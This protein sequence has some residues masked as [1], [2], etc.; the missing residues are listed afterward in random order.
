M[1]AAMGSA[2]DRPMG[3]MGQTPPETPPRERPELQA[4]RKFL[5]DL[6][7]LV[8]MTFAICNLHVCIFRCAKMRENPDFL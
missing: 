1:D 8:C 5:S 4:F 7:V 6:E 3:G 2:A